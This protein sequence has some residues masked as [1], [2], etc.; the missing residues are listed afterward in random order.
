MITQ[1]YVIVRPELVSGGLRVPVSIHSM[2]RDPHVHYYDPTKDN[3]KPKPSRYIEDDLQV[4]FG[5]RW[6]YVCGT[7]W[8]F[9]T[10]EEAHRIITAPGL[11]EAGLHFMGYN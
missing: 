9:L 3:N 8:D 6:R 10:D 11:N 2:E 1:H 7:D 5:K 4:L